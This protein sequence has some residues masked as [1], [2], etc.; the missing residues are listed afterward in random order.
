MLSR[1]G[2]HEHI[3]GV[4]VAQ[5]QAGVG[6]QVGQAVSAA[7]QALLG[8]P[9]GKGMQGEAGEG[10]V[11]FKAQ[12]ERGLG[13]RAATAGRGRQPGTEGC[14]PP[15]HPSPHTAAPS[16][17]N[18]HASG[19][20]CSLRPQH[21]WKGWCSLVEARLG[22]GN[23][24][25]QRQGG[26]GALLVLHRRRRDGRQGQVRQQQADLAAAIKWYREWMGC[27]CRRGGR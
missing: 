3:A 8:I 7:Q 12:R 26:G 2:T 18:C 5:R 24:G 19:S 4:A 9:V 22:A 13:Q 20:C 27:C 16:P 14:C 1:H 15:S 25:L 17:A 21:G 6:N 11:E 23:G 10:W